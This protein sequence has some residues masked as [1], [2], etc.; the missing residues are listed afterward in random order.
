M[1]DQLTLSSL[2]RQTLQEAAELYAQSVDEVG[3]FLQERGLSREQATSHLLGSVSEPVIPEH[4]RFVGMMSIPYVTP[5]GVVAIKF[6]NFSEHGP[7]YDAPA[8]QQTRMYNVSALQSEGDIVAICEGEL[9]A[10]VMTH[11]AG[12]PAVGIPGATQWD[13]HPWWARAFADYQQ[14][15]VIADH[16]LPK[17]GDKPDKV[18]PGQKHSAKVAKSIEGARVILPPP[19]LDLSDWVQAEGPEAVRRACGV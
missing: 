12:I 14:V 10:L 17:E 1:L 5:A 18:P 3:W 9:D 15:L 19:G 16:D 6:R 13:G 7:K 11:V 4:Q 2:Q 8:G